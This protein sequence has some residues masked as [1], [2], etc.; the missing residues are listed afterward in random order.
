MRS[1][2]GAHIDGSF[3]SPDGYAG[4]G[5]TLSGILISRTRKSDEGTGLDRRPDRVG[6]VNEV[7]WLRVLAYVISM[8]VAV[9]Q[10]NDAFDMAS[11]GLL[12]QPWIISPGLYI[13]LAS[14]A[15]LAAVRY[16]WRQRIRL[17]P[18]PVQILPK[19]LRNWLNRIYG[20]QAQE[21][22]QHRR[23]VG[24]GFAKISIDSGM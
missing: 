12:A 15:I 16:S 24:P 6:S 14:E 7:G 8:G 17:Q 23:E 11:P 22:I 9:K 3:P 5:S 21:Q 4:D 1:R 20:K 19:I 18:R 10:M 2:N 13:H